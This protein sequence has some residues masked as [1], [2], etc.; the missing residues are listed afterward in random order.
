M[1]K[2]MN[3]L[4][5]A[6]ADFVGKANIGYAGKNV[7]KK[8]VDGWNQGVE[9]A[10]QYILDEDENQKLKEAIEKYKNA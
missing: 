2:T 1:V 3:E 6:I 8:Y 4:L 7:D 9:M 5:K 10:Q